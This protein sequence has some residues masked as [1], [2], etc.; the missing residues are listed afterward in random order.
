MQ[1]MS[2]RDENR[3]LMENL[4]TSKVRLAEVQGDFLESRRALLRAREKQV[5]MA[6]QLTE[7]H[8]ATERAA[9]VEAGLQG[10]LVGVSSSPTTQA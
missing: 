3:A 6:K 5:Q 8:S 9:T 10:R 4:V 7:L 2:L 1:L